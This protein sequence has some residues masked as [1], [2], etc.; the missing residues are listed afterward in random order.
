MNS[1]GEKN[2]GI[3][4][5]L[6]LYFFSCQWL[7]SSSIGSCRWLPVK[8]TSAIERL[9]NVSLKLLTLDKKNNNSAGPE[10]KQVIP[11]MLPAVLLCHNNTIV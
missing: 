2:L 9:T 11:K 8:K 10:N 3:K 1:L 6:L 5:E 4:L 7:L